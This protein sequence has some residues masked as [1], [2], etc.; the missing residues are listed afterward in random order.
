M[1]PGAFA[2][3][4]GMYDPQLDIV[5]SPRRSVAGKVSTSHEG[6]FPRSLQI[7]STTLLEQ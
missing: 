4:Y 2:A 5:L 3:D 7:W 6:T 1:V